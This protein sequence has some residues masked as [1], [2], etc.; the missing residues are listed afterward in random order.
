MQE[1][2]LVGGH[3]GEEKGLARGRDGRGCLVRE[4][5]QGAITALLKLVR[6]EG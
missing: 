6:V 5:A 3:W 1:A 2:A 4:F